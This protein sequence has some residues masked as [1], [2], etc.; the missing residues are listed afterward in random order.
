MDG[1]SMDFPWNIHYTS[2]IPPLMEPSKHP[3]TMYVTIYD[4]VSIHGGTPMA[5]SFMKKTAD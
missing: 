4:R 1:F 2:G 3:E 5:G